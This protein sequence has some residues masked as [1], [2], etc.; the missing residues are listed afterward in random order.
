[1]KLEY[2][3]LPSIFAYKFN[4]RRYTQG[5]LGGFAALN[6]FMT[7]LV[8][9]ANLPNG[10]GLH[11]ATFQLNVS[12]F[13]GLRVHASTFRLDVISFC[14]LCWEIQRATAYQVKPRS[15]RLLFFDEEKRHSLS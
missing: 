12:A 13:Y 11:P 9:A 10:R 4:L 14:G 2:D 1:M 6:F 8:D 7:Y 15:G 3:K 5:L